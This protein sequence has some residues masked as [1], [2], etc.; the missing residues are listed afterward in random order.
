M[1]FILGARRLL[2][3]F[4]ERGPS[5]VVIDGGWIVEVRD[6]SG[7]VPDR[8]LAPGFVDLQV[9]GLDDVDV[10]RADGSDWD[11]L[12]RLLLGSGV[13]TW[14]PTIVTGPLD[15]YAGPLQRVAAAAA[16]SGGG[17]PTIAGAHLE[18]PFLGGA[19]GA[20]PR[21]H[22]APIDLAWLAALPDVV[23]IVTLAPELDGAV[24][25]I[26]ALAARGIL[27]S[28][29]HS[30]ASLEQATAGAAA[31]ARMV[32]HLFNGMGPL[33]HRQPGLPGAA[34]S[35]ARLAAGLIADLVHVH[36]AVLGPA[37]RALGPDRAVLVTDAVAWRA[38]RV[39]RVEIALGE[40]GAPR[41]PDGTLAGS[42]LSMDGAIRNVVAACGV[43]LT[44]AVTSASA[45]PARLL[46]LSDRGVIQPGR[47]ADLVA[48]SPSL[49]V[50]SVWVAGE[51]AA[52]A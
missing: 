25:A 9:N 26:A 35:D 20:H 52:A 45:T 50:E 42:A 48:L 38:A 51:A 37:L 8:I 11:R 27:V 21:Q 43:A 39:G 46:G 29:G 14:C 1:A 12:D 17:R 5:E 31:G 16:R 33:H 7:P 41:L 10:S 49:S 47:R 2:T 18:G 19:P 34:L 32:T 6:A 22:L 36:P 15:S 24:E 28:M 30:T 3:P 23:R 44:A 13:T 4:E 40:G